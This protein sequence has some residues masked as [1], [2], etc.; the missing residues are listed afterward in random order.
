MK[1]P[2]C[3]KWASV[4]ETRTRKDGVVRRRYVCANLHKFTTLE[5]LVEKK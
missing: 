1:C 5:V 3:K 4:L 2:E